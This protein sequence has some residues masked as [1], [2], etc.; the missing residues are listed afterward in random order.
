VALTPWPTTAAD[1]A[2]ATAALKAVIGPDLSDDRV[3]ALGSAASALVER[4]AALAPL[5]IRE[6]A[7]RRTS[8]WLAEQPSAA[9]RSETVG[10]VTT[11][12]AA[13]HTGALRHS[14]SMALL[15]PWKVRRAGTIG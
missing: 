4:F 13:T 8:G 6:E 12:Y 15:G 1:I 10:D 14:G 7:V 11:S 9:V 3:Q 2:T 5:P